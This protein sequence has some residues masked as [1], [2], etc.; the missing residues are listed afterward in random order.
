[1]LVDLD[2]KKERSIS[3]GPVTE[4]AV[5][6]ARESVAFHLNCDRES[7]S[8]ELAQPPKGGFVALF[9]LIHCLSPS[10]QLKQLRP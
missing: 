4:T 9:S 3:H 1:M 5:L 8:P 6:N 7:V 2:L 10:A